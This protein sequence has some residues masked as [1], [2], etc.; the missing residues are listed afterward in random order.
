MDVLS[1]IDKDL[2]PFS[3]DYSCD[4][5]NPFS[6]VM[7][8]RQTD[9]EDMVRNFDSIDIVNSSSDDYDDIVPIEDEDHK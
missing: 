6:A 4:G 9:D 3:P 7:K 1:G 5:I 8:P 2:N